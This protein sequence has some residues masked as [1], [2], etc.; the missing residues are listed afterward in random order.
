VFYNVYN[1]VITLIDDVNDVNVVVITS[2]KNIMFFISVKK[3]VFW[4]FFGG[5][6][7]GR[8]R[9]IFEGFWASK[10]HAL[11]TAHLYDVS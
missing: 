10:S 3:G 11:I 5:P 1:V 6:G 2:C 4:P 8:K 7:G 9:P